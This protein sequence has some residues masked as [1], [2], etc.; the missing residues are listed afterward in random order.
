MSLDRGPRGRRRGALRGLPALPLPGELGEEPVPLAVRGARTAAAPLPPRF[1]EAP[2]CRCSACWTCP[3]LRGR[4]AHHRDGPPAVPAAAGRDGRAAA[5]PQITARVTELDVDGERCCS[6]DEAVEREVTARRRTPSR[7]RWTGPG[8]ARWSRCR[9]ARRSRRSGTAPA[10]PSAGSCAAARRW[11]RAVTVAAEHDDGLGAADRHRRRTPTRTGR[12][13][14]TTAVRALADRRAPAARGRRRRVRVAARPAGRGAAAAARLP[15]GA[16]LARAG[17]R[18]RATTDMLLG[19]PI[20]LYDHP[21][22]AGR[23]R[24]ARCSTPP[25]STRSSPCG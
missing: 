4:P 10:P 18:R 6:W 12:R 19:S 11:P 22:I 24:R 9:A 5:R 8:T 23:E 2:A 1:G 16:L 3:P 7:C 17:R 15:P 20:I 14:R 25:R 13:P 21:E